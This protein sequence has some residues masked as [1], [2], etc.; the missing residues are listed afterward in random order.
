MTSADCV[1]ITQNTHTHTHTPR[2]ARNPSQADRTTWQKKQELMGNRPNGKDWKW[3]GEGQPH[4]DEYSEKQT[5]SSARPMGRSRG[6]WDTYEPF[7]RDRWVLSGFRSAA[8]VEPF[9]SQFNK[10][11]WLPLARD[12]PFM[13][14]HYCCN[15]M[16]KS[17]LAKFQKQTGMYPFLGTMAEES[18]LRTQAWIRHGCNAFEGSKHTSQPLSFWTEQDILL[19]TLKSELPLASVYGEIVAVDENGQEYDPSS[20]IGGCGKLKCTG[21]QRT[22]CIFCGFGAHLEKPGEGRFERL[23]FTHPKQY[24]YCING[25]QWVDNPAYDPTAPEYDGEWKNW[26]PK[27]IWVPSKKGLGMGKVFDMT[28]EIYGKDFIRY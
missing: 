20:L 16:K 18:R 6:S 17:P 2:R 9:K 26:N 14:S 4:P 5:D 13:I 23:A 25:G 15:V 22:G 3:G 19:Y 12:V 28:N 10:E 21:C 1:T 8:G 11:R 24:D 27:K 7:Q